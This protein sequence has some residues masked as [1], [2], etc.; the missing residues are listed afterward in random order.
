MRGTNLRGILV[1]GEVERIGLALGAESSEGVLRSDVAEVGD[2][3]ELPVEY[4][5]DLLRVSLA[6]IGRS[7]TDGNLPV[8]PIMRVPGC[9]CFPS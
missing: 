7:G 5:D 6:L 8:H 9:Y 2:E 3:D 1:E 4:L